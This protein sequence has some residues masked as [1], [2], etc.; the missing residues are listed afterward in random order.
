M[1]ILE[2]CAN[3]TTKLRTGY[4]SS[5]S[6]CCDFTQLTAD[7]TIY[8]TSEKSNTHLKQRHTH[9]HHHHGFKIKHTN[10]AAVS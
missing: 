8:Y 3:F 10:K 5:D 2:K 4:K 6:A 1:T 9:H 7:N